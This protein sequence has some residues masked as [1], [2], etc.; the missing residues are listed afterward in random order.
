MRA[1]DQV[2]ARLRD[3]NNGT[4]WRD[5]NDVGLHHRM[6][7]DTAT[8]TATGARWWK[9]QR[10]PVRVRTDGT[11]GREQLI[12]AEEGRLKLWRRQSGRDLATGE[13]LR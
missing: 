12:L 2:P 6:E 7:L 5:C 10:C 13:L 3:Q 8:T 1:L 11:M 4:A 9:C